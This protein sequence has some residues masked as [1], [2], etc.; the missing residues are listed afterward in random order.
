MVTARIYSRVFITK[1]PGADDLLISIAAGFGIALSVMIITQ[2]K[3]WYIGRHIWDVPVSKFAGQRLNL[4][5]CEYLYLVATCSVKISILLFYR[6]LSVTF[7]KT[8]LVATWAGILYNVLYF[9]GFAIGLLLLFNPTDSYWLSFDPIWATTHHY[10]RGDEAASLPTS[11]A[12]SVFGDFYSTVLPLLLIRFLDLPA[13]QKA[14]LYALFCLG[15]L[16]VAAGIIRTIILDRVVSKTYDVTW[17]LW[18]NWIWT[19]VELH[20][21]IWAA[22]AP[23]LKPFFRR[24]LIDPIISSH[25]HASYAYGSHRRNSFGKPKGSR[26]LWSNNTSTARDSIPVDVEK[27]GIALSKPQS[28]AEMIEEEINGST[29]TRHYQIRT[30]RDGKLAPMQVHEQKRFDGHSAHTANSA[31]YILQKGGRSDCE[32]SSESRQYRSENERLPSIPNHQQYQ[33]DDLSYYKS[34][35]GV[36]QPV[37]PSLTL[38]SRA[39]PLARNN[40]Q[41]SAKSRSGS[42][43]TRVQP[44][45][46][47]PSHAHHRSISR[48][49]ER[50]FSLPSSTVVRSGPYQHQRFEETEERDRRSSASSLGLPRQGSQI[51]LRTEAMEHA[52]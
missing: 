45:Q 49:S 44:L 20:V 40:S 12:L 36:G 34:D 19:V 31:D 47:Q 23:A 25:R 28:K 13:R 22:S 26:R 16:V 51:G 11:G 9:L 4:F 50:N 41:S 42:S 21:A 8:F 39:S 32:T 2:Q 24:F 33:L 30:S 43:K 7:S 5:I 10:S 38:T 15:F 52:I 48:G 1:A 3:N 37:L 17:T 14:A 6:R 35:A 18:E 27:I 29:S 46:E